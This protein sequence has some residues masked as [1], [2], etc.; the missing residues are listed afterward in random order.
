MIEDIKEQGQTNFLDNVMNMINQHLTTQN[1]IIIVSIVV[2]VC[3]FWYFFLY[4]QLSGGESHL[5]DLSS[6][7]SSLNES[8]IF[9]DESINGGEALPRCTI[10]YVQLLVVQVLKPT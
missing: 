8:E 4:N 5:T 2:V 3:L 1:I 6:N 10:Y 9:S 7:E